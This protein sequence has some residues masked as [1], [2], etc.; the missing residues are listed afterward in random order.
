MIS[1]DFKYEQLDVNQIELDINNPRISNYVGMYGNNLNAEQM[2]LALGAGDRTAGDGTTFYS[3][4]EAIKTSGGIINPIIV[5]RDTQKGKSTVIEGNTRVL[6]YREFKESDKEQGSSKWLKIPSIVYT[7]LEPAHID[8]IRLQAH[9]VGPRAWDPYSKAKYLDFLSNSEHLS[10]NQIIDF[11]GGQGREINDYISA[12]GDMEKYYRPIVDEDMFDPTRFSAF[13][14]LQRPRVLNAIFQAKFSK[15][16]F[17]K[18]VRDQLISP[19]NTVRDL[20]KILQ[21]PRSKEAFLRDGAKEAI[22]LLEIPTPDAAL[23]DASLEQLT[24]EISKR[25]RNMPFSDIQRLRADLTT[26]EN[27]KI[28]EACEQ[29]NQLC[30]EIAS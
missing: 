23:K 29:L 19:L 10:T 28:R 11:C 24:Q 17:A 13:V 16:D 12:Y 7:D 30:R 5:N 8:A 9:L 26:D 18:W 22:K 14:E 21:S 6:I 27:D 20:P 25:I 3:L 15:A 4:R 2:S 1:R